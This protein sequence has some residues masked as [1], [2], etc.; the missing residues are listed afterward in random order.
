M[1]FVTVGLSAGTLLAM[2]I[3][4]SYILG[5]ASRKF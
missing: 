1:N 3:V 5:W 4:L 2:G